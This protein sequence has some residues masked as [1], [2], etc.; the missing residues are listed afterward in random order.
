MAI[1]DILI[2]VALLLS[3]TG[4][5]FAAEDPCANSHDDGLLASWYGAGFDGK[6]TAS[7]TIFRASDPTMIAHPFLPF[8]SKIRLTNC[9]NGKSIVAYVVDRGPFRDDKNIIVDVSKAAARKL[10]F[11]V[12]GIAPIAIELLEIP[13]V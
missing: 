5:G 8:G 11:L 13:H 10:D 2:S 1:R 3:A 7:G 6:K 4:V 9:D 12:K